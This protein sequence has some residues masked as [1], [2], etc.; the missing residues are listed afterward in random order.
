LI[1]LLNAYFPAR[2]LFLGV[3]EACLITLA[4]LVATVARLGSDAPSYLFNYQHGSYKIL[5]AS[6]AIIVCMYYFDLYESSI[7]GNRRE[8]VIRLTEMLGT[9]YSLS[10]LLYYLY[11]PLELGRGIFVIGLFI[12][13]MLLLLWRELFLKINRVPKF[14]ARTLI[15][16]DGATGELLVRELEL[17]PELG[18]RVVG[19][20]KDL[21]NGHGR[22]A[23][24][25]KEAPAESFLSSVNYYQ[26]DHI[27]VA[28]G[29]RRGC[30]PLE[31][32]LELKSHGVIIHDSAELYEAVTGKVPVE[33]LRLSWLLF[34]PSISASRTWATCKR[35]VSFALFSIVLVA[36][37]P[38]MALIAL[39]I[40][41][42]AGFPVI[43]KQDR[44]GRHG[45]IFTLYKFRTMIAGAD[46]DDNHRPAGIT[47]SRFTR[48][49][50]ILRRARLDELPQL[51][52][53]VLGDMAFIGP[54]PFVPDQEQECLENIPHYRQRWAVRPGLTG[55]AQVNRGYCV[56]L[57]DNK[58]K[59][60][61]D[62]FYIK[63]QSLGLDLLI[64]LKT[65]KVFLLGRG[66]R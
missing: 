66:A 54:R 45:K 2:T 32:L 13:A 4:F 16:G 35:F 58:E 60:A 38:L 51:V 61:Y 48:C 59:L 41:L 8:M 17:R 22:P 12:I 57:E 39:A 1:R 43:Y 33:F 44:V 14:A 50:R 62:L 21:D 18:M 19:Q 25:A 64:V 46:G 31:A 6:L 56:T 47:D 34:S 53:I 5:V 40:F 42:D 52:N 10:V 15:L 20:L 63:N 11:P 28:L 24:G 29:E 26:P 37:L 9:V 7:L 55:W 30:L 49:G 23:P 27:I 65:M 3:S 36:M